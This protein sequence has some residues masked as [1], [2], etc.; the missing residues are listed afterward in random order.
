M[1]GK[2]SEIAIAVR[3]LTKSYGSFEAVRGIDFEV[4]RGEVAALL[5]PN[6]AGKT[7]TVEILEGFRTR[8][9]GTVSVLGADPERRPRS[10]RAKVGIVLQECAVEP[11]LTVAE[12]VTQRAGLYAAPR[13][14]GEVIELVGLVEKARSRVKTLSGGQQ[15][16][17][18]LGLALIG[19]PELIFLDEPTTG[20]DPSARREAWDVVRGLCAEGRTVVLTTH[21]MDEAQALADTVTVI[22]AGRVVA[23]GPPDTLGGRDHG[24]SAVRFALPPGT[25]LG[26]LPLPAGVAPELRAGFV[27]FHVA[28]PTPVLHALTGWALERG[29]VLIGLAVAR[30]T[31]EDVYLDLT[32]EAPS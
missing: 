25:S 13:S 4:G 28:E 19:D 7:T 14:V 15:R 22:A 17:L 3:G 31:L 23:S 12:A 21:Y 2:D 24:E 6:G 32:G 11:Y 27:E 5:G 1:A 18:D 8:D 29:E 20:F 30:P 26:D 10:L 16:R 9:G